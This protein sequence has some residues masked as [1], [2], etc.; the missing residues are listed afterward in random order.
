[1]RADWKDLKLSVEL[2]VGFGVVLAL[3]AGLAVPVVSIERTQCSLFIRGGFGVAAVD[4]SSVRSSHIRDA[5]GDHSGVEPD[6]VQAAEESGVLDLHT[7]VHHH[8]E[9]G[10]DRTLCGLPVLDAEL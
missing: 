5:R 4:S 1:M 7:A 9:P 10:V 3:L 6:G 8:V 2:S